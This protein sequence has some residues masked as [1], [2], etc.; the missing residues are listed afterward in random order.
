[1][2]DLKPCPFCGGEAS[3]V[4]GYS[5]REEREFFKVF[6][7]QCQCRTAEWLTLRYAAEVWN[8]RPNGGAS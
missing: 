1:M 8:T 5:P 6:C 2:T 4:R 3:Y 7:K